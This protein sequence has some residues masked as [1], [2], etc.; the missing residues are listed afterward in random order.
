MLISLITVLP[1]SPSESLKSRKKAILVGVILGNMSSP[2]Y[3]FKHFNRLT[4]LAALFFSG[5]I[6][7]SYLAMISLKTTLSVIE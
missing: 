1:E 5:V 7:S 4:S 3:L 2:K 6:S